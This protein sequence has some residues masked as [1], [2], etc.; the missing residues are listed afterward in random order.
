M[1]KRVI[2]VHD[3]SCVGKCS[4]TVALPVLSATGIETS[5]LPTAVLSTHTG[6]FTGFTRRDLTE[7]MQPILKHWKSLP[8]PADAVY[9][10]YLGSF[11]QLDIV[12]GLFDTYKAQG[13]LLFAD[14]VMADNGKLYGGFTGD[15][16]AGMAQL[17]AKA[18]VIVPN[19]TEA[20]LML[21][22][23]YADGGYDEAYIKGLLTRLTGL[24][25]RTAVLTGISFEKDRIGAVSYDRCAGEYA[26]YFSERIDG[27]FHGTGDVFA[28]ALL[29]A[30]LHEKPWNEALKIAVKFTV[31][32]I[33]RTLEAGTERRYGVDF[34]NGLYELAGEIRRTERGAMQSILQG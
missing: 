17:C 29:A 15:F 26:S 6:G 8:L 12:S 24:G 16:P 13:A 20:A 21:N 4:L 2:A 19:L 9:S 30:V 18:D 23:P 11:D 10:G 28:S 22:E 27:Y 7:D 3:I 25:P 1:Q 33:R 32:C 5:I 31:G 14:P 34:E